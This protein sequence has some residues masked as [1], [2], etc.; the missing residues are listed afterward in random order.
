MIDPRQ[1]LFA[2]ALSSFP[3]FCGILEVKDKSGKYVPFVLNEI[4]RRYVAGMSSRDIIVKGRQVGMTTLLLA[5]DI[6]NFLTVPGANVVV[7]CQSKQDNG[8]RNKVVDEIKHH[9]DHL[10]K[11]GLK[12]PFATKNKGD[13]RL[14]NG[15]H[16]KVDVAGASPK[17]A[18][19]AARGDS[20]HVLHCTEVAYWDLASDTWNGLSKCVPPK[21]MGSR[22]VLECTPNGASGFF[23][24]E[25]KAAYEGRTEYTAQFFPWYLQKEY[26]TPLDPGEVI[27]PNNALESRLEPEQVKWY[28]RQLMGEKGHLA[29][30]E[31]P[32]DRDSCFLGMGRGFF[33]AEKVIGMLGA[34]QDY[35][36]PATY[37]IDRKCELTPSKIL[38]SDSQFTELR[39]LRI[40]HPPTRAARGTG[41]EYV[42][43]LDPSEGVGLDA[44]TGIVLERGTGKHC[45][46]IYGQFKPEELARVAVRVAMMYNGAEIACERNNHGHA[47]RVALTVGYASCGLRAP[48]KKLFYDHDRKIG[49][50]NTLQSRTLS[51]DHLE[52]AVRKGRFVTND[53]WLLREMKDFIVKETSGG[54]AR[55]EAERGKHDDLVLASVIAWNIISRRRTRTDFSALPPG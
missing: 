18:E 48:Y 43:A 40:F 30:Q 32:S 35:E 41:G 33:N 12:V 38:A 1:E 10:E 42:L 14:D 34:A 47:V 21:E 45:A 20:I 29:A 55:A 25:F 22:I 27:T 3:L 37:T 17:S 2:K 50:I 36:A 52:A 13:W 49:W 53:V 46:T 9:F 31:Y 54:K 39:T 7:V 26:R 23:Y 6:F 8:P 16:L 5:W 11:L 24:E 15:A 51:L 4:Q 28:R 44:G 19:K